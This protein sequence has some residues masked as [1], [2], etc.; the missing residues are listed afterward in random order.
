MIEKLLGSFF[1]WRFD[2]FKNFDSFRFGWC[3]WCGRSRFNSWCW[4]ERWFC[5]AGCLV[6]LGDLV[7]RSVNWDADHTFR[8]VNDF[9]ASQFRD[10]CSTCFVSLGL[11]CLFGSQVGRIGLL[12]QV[13]DEDNDCEGRNC[14]DAT[15]KGEHAIIDRWFFVR[16]LKITPCS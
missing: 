5:F 3:D 10:A 15:E 6:S 7:H 16:H 11:A 13:S 12:W 8:C 14:S 4:E 9:V 2:C 1:R